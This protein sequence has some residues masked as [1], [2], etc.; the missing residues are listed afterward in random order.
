MS[1]YK[2][3]QIFLEKNPDKALLAY[4][5]GSGKSFTAKLWLEK[6]R[7]TN[8]LIVCPKQIKQ[9]WIET[10]TKAQVMT[11][12]EFVK[13]PP[14][15]ASALVVDECDL[16][17]SPLFTKGR[18]QRSVVMYNFIRAN[19]NMPVLL[20]SATPIR[21][22]PHNLHTLLCFMG[23]Y[24]PW[25]EWRQ[26]FYVLETRPYL[27]R[28]A[29]HPKPD[30]RTDIRTVLEKYAHIALM[31]DVIKEMPEERHEVIR[32]KNDKFKITESEPMAAFV[33]EH[34]HEQKNKTQTILDIGRRF[35][36]VMVI[37]HYRD[38]ID[39]LEK[40]LSHDRKVYVLHGGIS[41]Q[42]QVIKNAQEDDEC[43]FI[44]QASLAAGFDADTFS[45]MIFASMSYKVRDYVQA[46]ARI[47]RIHALHDIEY[48][49]LIGGRRDKVIYDT[50]QKGRDF[51]PSEY[52]NTSGI[53]TSIQERDDR[54]AIFGEGF[55][56]SS[57]SLV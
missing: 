10:R 47:K 26:R 4:E 24:I 31:R 8:A 17:A 37:V 18:S 16:F 56:G 35:R 55:S 13:Q 19:P 51:I 36:K 9:A 46:K 25:S 15:T 12:Q 43:F 14:A 44:M 52:L 40:Q 54:E 27:R 1:L 23:V 22:A 20:C 11:V 39:E 33:E 32:L 7:D 34:R 29:W 42:G 53:T 50:V 38:Q 2:H 57:E 3:Q 45:C 48:Y 5:A 6:G 49:Y 30:W 41:N 28:I 21:S